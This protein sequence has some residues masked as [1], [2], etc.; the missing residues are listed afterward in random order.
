MIPR[1]NATL[2]AERLLANRKRDSKKCRHL[3]APGFKVII[4]WECDVA[5]EPQLEARLRRL[6]IRPDA[7]SC[8]R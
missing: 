7:W 4:V 3:R 8:R 5:N 6:L 2:W 1:H